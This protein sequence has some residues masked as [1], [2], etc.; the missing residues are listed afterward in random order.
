MLP[1]RIKANFAPAAA[2][3]PQSI[4][5]CHLLTS[6]PRTRGFAARSDSV[7]AKGEI[8]TFVEMIEMVST[9]GNSPIT[10]LLVKLVITAAGE[11]PQPADVTLID[12]HVQHLP[13]LV[14]VQF[15]MLAQH[16]LD[17]ECIR[18]RNGLLEIGCQVRQN[19][20][21]RY[22]FHRHTRPSLCW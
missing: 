12:Q 18:R 4:T 14:R 22:I 1:A 9:A 5:P 21:F 11:P 15:R 8:S 3:L 2:H 17:R 7:S 20:F 16:I 10:H 6:T 19:F 13:R